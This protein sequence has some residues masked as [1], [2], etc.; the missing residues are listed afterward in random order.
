MP[1]VWCVDDMDGVKLFSTYCTLH[2]HSCRL[3]DRIADLF[4]HCVSGCMTAQVKQIEYLCTL[5]TVIN[6]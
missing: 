4:Y 2:L 1:Q 5:N 6:S 3:I